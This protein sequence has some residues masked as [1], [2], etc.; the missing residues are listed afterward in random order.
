MN[1]AVLRHPEDKIMAAFVDGT[2]AP[3][4]L[5]AVAEHL[6]GCAD[7]RMIV[8]ETAR[9]ERQEQREEQKKSPRQWWWLAVAAI[10]AAIAI[11]IPL[12]R[13]PASPI[14]QLVAAAPREHRGVEARLSDFPWARLQSPTRGTPRPD[15]ADLKLAGAAGDVLDDARKN[16]TP[17][18]RHAEGVA[19]L[20][21]NRPADSLAA[22]EEAARNS[23]EARVWND[24]AA[25]RYALAVGEERPSLLPLAL[26][27]VRQALQLDPKF[28]PALFNRALIVER[29]GV[30][31]LAR[32]AW[33]QAID[34]DPGSAW[35]VEAREHLRKLSESGQRFDP[36]MLETMPP[37]TLV[38]QFPQEAR[39]WGEGPMLAQWADAW[40]DAGAS[41][42]DLLLARVRALGLALA[43]AS[44]ERMLADAVAAID[45]SRGR[46]REALVT[47]HR[48]NRDA[49]ILLNNGSPGAAEPM[50]RRAAALLRE[51]G[52]PMARQADYFAAC[53]VLDQNRGGE[54]YAEL[55][56]LRDSV[57]VARHRAFA[58]QIHWELSVYA[59]GAG[60]WGTATR[61]ADAGAAIFR[62]LGE[63]ANASFLD[64][65]AAVALEAIGDSDA[66]WM[67]RTGAFPYLTG[68]RLTAILASAGTI[69]TSV[70]Q[71]AAAGA[72]LD[73][74][75]DTVRTGDP[76]QLGI[77]LADRARAVGD[78]ADLDDARAA[79]ARV[80]D[81]AMRKNVEAQIDVADAMLRRANDPRAAITALN[82]AVAFFREGGFGVLLPD[83][84]L[85][86][87]RAFRAAGEEQAAIADYAA[88]LSEVAKQRTTTDA[89]PMRL[90]D[91]SARL[92]EETVDLHLARGAVAEA[93]AVADETYK[94]ARI[95]ATVA[96]IEYTVL[97]RAV[98]IFCMSRG[99]L[100]AARV[101]V[102]RHELDLLV[103]SLAARIQS[104]ASI[105]EIRVDGARLYRWLI[106]PLQ[107]QLQ[108][109]DELVLVPGPRLQ[110]VPFAALWDGKGWLIDRFVI[111]LAPAAG[112][113]RAVEH[114]S[115][116]PA[117][118]VA[119]PPAE[120]S[121]RLAASREE[122]SR[123]AAGYR[124]TLLAG[125]EAT[126]AAFFDAAPRSA[127]IHFA[128]HANS[129]AYGALLLADGV[130]GAS[131]IA[132]LQLTQHPLV[133]LAACG[134]F[135]GD[136]TRVAG[137]S[138]LA[139]AFIAAGAG[140]VVGTLWEVDDDVSS[141][142]FLRFHDHLRGGASPARALRAAQLEMTRSSDARLRHPATWSPAEILTS[143]NRES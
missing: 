13:R 93:L 118:V 106:A 108:G 40:A 41:H 90:R 50:L 56:R 25:A 143:N 53:A 109:V 39:K 10:V 43:A 22:L 47:A 17:E 19:Y 133:V 23:K 132:R 31:D 67:R 26:S 107:S 77:E 120:G 79:A 65:L 110:A 7:C 52:S 80:R 91:T 97:P 5:V 9:F 117:L 136:A 61:E 70:D 111:R 69:L 138:T 125:A 101:D 71:P 87:A 116:E 64:G 100:H 74:A 83:A 75:V 24:L 142:L 81:A 115:F 66:A 27:D 20:L 134:T 128:G 33:Q 114:E 113:A 58:A 63:T 16:T 96:V 32:T 36:R 34:A 42:A 72:M 51:G 46:A 6:R 98:A 29:M 102:E 124:G 12:L 105:E 85:Q 48:L 76:A 4:E 18:S 127:L 139:R 30:R 11:T 2:L 57:D 35:S 103:A 104:R 141:T 21:I 86:R 137:M 15:P 135:R 112:A 55:T 38:R 89:D 140:S 99:G 68:G 28:A 49:R 37:A 88:G 92:I 54:A 82:R 121:P 95:P 130:A 131:D 45:R 1:D 126:R 62:A 8:A 73:L 78:R 122:A 60:D 119:D 94:T 59:N 3:H 129:D 84:Y 14:A 44:G 123:I